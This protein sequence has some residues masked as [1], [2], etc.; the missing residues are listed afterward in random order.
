MPVR[1]A[2]HTCGFLHGTIG[3]FDLAGHPGDGADILIR[4][5]ALGRA[6]SWRL[7][8]RAVALMRGHGFTAVAAAVPEVVF[9]AVCTTLNCRLQL[10][11][12]RL[13]EPR[14]LPAAEADA[15][16][17]STMGQAD[18]AWDLRVARFA[19]LGDQRSPTGRA[20]AAADGERG[21]T[22]RHWIGD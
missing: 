15:C 16:E 22:A 11:A 21:R 2:A 1:P 6:L 13:G 7:G 10:D 9:R 12:L 14:R 17:S 5:P 20:D 19:V 3:A 4:T 8:D 18:R